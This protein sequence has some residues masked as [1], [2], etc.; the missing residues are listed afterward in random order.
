MSAAGAAGTDPLARQIPAVL[1]L[2]PARNGSTFQP[3]KCVPR[4]F[5]KLFNVFYKRS[6]VRFLLIDTNIAGYDGHPYR[7]AVH[8]LQAARKRG[9][10]TILATNTTYH[11]D[12][13]PAT[14]IS[15]YTYAVDDLSLYP[16]ILWAC[17]R[18]S[19]K[20]RLAKAINLGAADSIALDYMLNTYLRPFRSRLD[21]FKMQTR[22]LCDSLCIDKTDVVFCS[23]ST[24]LTALGA[25]RSC[26]SPPRPLEFLITR[27]VVPHS[28]AP[29]NTGVSAVYSK[30][31]SSVA[32]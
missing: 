3:Q 1:A 4:H 15:A 28:D 10:E 23:N 9:Y 5:Q 30:D 27:G 19:L 7:Y 13:V 32:H 26:T 31:T 22:E 2:G 16:T 12:G 17:D 21:M 18:H 25:A 24:F 6:H 14:V 29:K 20:Q 11:V 8:C